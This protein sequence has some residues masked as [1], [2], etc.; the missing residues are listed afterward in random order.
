MFSKPPAPKGFTPVGSALFSNCIH[1]SQ[2]GVRLARSN[3]SFQKRQKELARK[4]KKE[5]KRKRK[6]EKKTIANEV[7]ADEAGNGDG[8]DQPQDDG[9]DQ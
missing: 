3:F 9:V 4:K 6:M 7:G 1:I 8:P 5:E 2:G